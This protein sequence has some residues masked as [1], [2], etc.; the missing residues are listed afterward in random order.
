MQVL[1]FSVRNA[2]GPISE[3][4]EK[5]TTFSIPDSVRPSSGFII[6]SHANARKISVTFKRSPSEK[7]KETQADLDGIY[8]KKP[9]GFNKP[10]S[11][12][13]Q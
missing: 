5:Y 8:V 13:M 10:D 9:D 2:C 4:K 11:E 7:F 12:D 6:G 3:R 1:K